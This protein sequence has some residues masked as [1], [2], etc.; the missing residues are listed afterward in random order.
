MA[1]SSKNPSPQDLKKK[2]SPSRRG[3]AR[4]STAAINVNPNLK[5]S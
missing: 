1:T 4:D 5:V 2:D 3:E